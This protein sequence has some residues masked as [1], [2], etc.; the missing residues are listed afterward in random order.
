MCIHNILKKPIYNNFRS[1]FIANHPDIIAK[2]YK[3]DL[4]YILVD[5]PLH[6]KAIKALLNIDLEYVNLKNMNLSPSAMLLLFQKLS[7]PNSGMTVD[8]FKICKNITK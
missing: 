8:V 6:D 7:D 3:H 5:S 2:I 4:Y 1:M